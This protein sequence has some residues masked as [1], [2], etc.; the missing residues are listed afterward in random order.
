VGCMRLDGRSRLGVTMARPD[1]RAQAVRKKDDVQ[2]L[3]GA[4]IGKRRVMRDAGWGGRCWTWP[5][6][7]SRLGGSLVWKGS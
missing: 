5:S 7:V 2:L 4:S 1:R 3:V 6:S